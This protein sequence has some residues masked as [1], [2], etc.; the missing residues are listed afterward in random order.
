MERQREGLDD[1]GTQG[2]KAGGGPVLSSRVGHYGE[3]QTDQGV[4]PLGRSGGAG[5]F[6]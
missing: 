6:T 5:G 3:S 2:G 4:T 1:S